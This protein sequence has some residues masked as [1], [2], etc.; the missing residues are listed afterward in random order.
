MSDDQRNLSSLLL[1]PCE[2]CDGTGVGAHH[3]TCP[4]CAGTKVDPSAVGG[5]LEAAHL[6]LNDW[7]VNGDE[8]ARLDLIALLE[9]DSG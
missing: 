7:L 6:A 3:G 1:D 2:E 4:R 5:R 8:Q 9:D